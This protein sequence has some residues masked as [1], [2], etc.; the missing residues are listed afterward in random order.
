MAAQTCMIEI[1]KMMARSLPDTRPTGPV[2]VRTTARAAA[3]ASAINPKIAIVT[4]LVH[5]KVFSFAGNGYLQI[6]QKNYSKKLD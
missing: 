5:L 6:W 4:S 3:N 1:W 2:I